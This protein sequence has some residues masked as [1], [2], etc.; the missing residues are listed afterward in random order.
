L[1]GYNT[2]FSDGE[3]LISGFELGSGC[4][5]NWIAWLINLYMFALGLF[6]RP[7]ALYWAFLRGRESLSV[8]SL[9]EGRTTLERLTA[10]IA[11][12]API[13]AIALGLRTLLR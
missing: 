11:M 7:R 12:S 8:Y 9:R 13:A 6:V 2:V 1:T 3:M 4:G 5:S 10:L